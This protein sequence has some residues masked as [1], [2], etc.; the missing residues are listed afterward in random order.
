MYCIRVNS[1]CMKCKQILYSSLNN[2][3]SPEWVII[4]Y[5]LIFIFHY[6]YLSHPAVRS[7]PFE[8]NGDTREHCV[9]DLSSAFHKLFT[10]A[11][12][13]FFCSVCLIAQL[14]FVLS[15]WVHRMTKS[16]NLHQPLIIILLIQKC[17]IFFAYM[18]LCHV[19]HQYNVIIYV[20]AWG[21]YF[22]TF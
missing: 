20:F 12:V 2:I 5:L 13:W 21:N 11:G 10:P 16:F 7:V 18:Y 6:C 15:Q 19:L 4:F 1:D 14:Y 17:I 3:L 9:A 22:S 8:P